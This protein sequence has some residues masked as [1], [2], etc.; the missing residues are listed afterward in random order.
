MKRLIWFRNDLRISDNQAVHAACKNNIDSKILAIFLA[1]IQ[2]WK[3]YHISAKQINFIYENLSY[4]EEKLWEIDIH[5]IYHECTDFEDCIN[6]L[7]YF[8]K[9][10]NIKEIFYNRQYEFDEKNRDFKLENI[11]KSH[12]VDCKKFDDTLI[13][14]PGTILNKKKNLYRRY[15]PFKKKFLKK[16]AKNTYKLLKYPKK[17]TFKK[18]TKNTCVPNFYQSKFFKAGEQSALNHLTFFLKNLSKNYNNTRKIFHNTDSTSNLSP[19]LT[20]G[21]LS[22]QQCF[23]ILNNLYPNF[24]EK[25]H[26]S[27]Y[28]FDQII[29]REFYQHIIYG[30]PLLSMNQPFIKWTEDI[31]WKNNI[32]Q[33]EAW[34]SGETGYPLIDA[35]MRQLNTT[36]WIHNRLRMISASFLTKNLL[37]NWKIGEEYFMSKL[38]DGNFSANNSGWQWCAST[39]IH[40][41]PYFRIFNPSLQG[42][43][44]DIKGK[45]IKKWLPELRDVPNKYIYT[46]Y[47][48]TKSKKYQLKY[49]KPIIDYNYSKKNAILE[50]SKAKEKNNK[51]NK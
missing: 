14:K 36:G 23:C 28:W 48:W 45:F 47:N 10:E 39:G 29:W 16:L 37:V 30:Y 43:L 3:K 17:F 35:T 11:L 38:L 12:G 9:N 26:F 24:L 27:L 1:P 5:L 13:F 51:Q 7:I 22:P 25:K 41:T 42:R 44:Y 33:I 31:K 18:F 49:P 6:F 2:Q 8:C 21:V 15:I 19:Y 32:Y 46:P 4:L 40:I 34:K 20:I 50:Y